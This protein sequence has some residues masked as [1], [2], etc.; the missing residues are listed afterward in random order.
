MTIVFD[1]TIQNPIGNLYRKNH[2][3]VLI[4]TIDGS[5]I[6]AKK[7]GF[8]PNHIARMLGGG[9]KENE[10]PR[11]AARREL[12]EEL[13]LPLDEKAFRK[14]GEV[15]THAQTTEGLMC[16]TTHLYTVA[17]PKDADM[18]PGDD[19]TGIARYTREEYIMLVGSMNELHGEYVTDTFSFSWHD[20][21][22][23][24]APIHEFA[25]KTYEANLQ[26]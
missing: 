10:D 6:L 19:I 11:A 8:Y 25:L 12:L 24:Y 22:K 15:E 3:L 7:L 17:L 2:V 21:G 18:V 1:T 23:I 9:I 16:M 26:N 4:V 14:L 20:W 13:A 5:F